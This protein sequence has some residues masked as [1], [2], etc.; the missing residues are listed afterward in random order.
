MGEKALRS[1]VK[2]VKSSLDISAGTSGDDP[3]IPAQGK[4][5][6]KSEYQTYFI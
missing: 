6:K 2:D 5:D 3:D 1:S 4:G